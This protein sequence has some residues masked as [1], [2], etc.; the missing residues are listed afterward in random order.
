MLA[1]LAMGT[2][3]TSPLA[4]AEHA[5]ES[6]KDMADLPKAVSDMAAVTVANKVT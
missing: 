3:F 5:V 2:L 1:L 4:E 6:W